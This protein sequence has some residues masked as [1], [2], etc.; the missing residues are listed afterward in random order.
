[1]SYTAGSF[2]FG[3]QPSASKWN[4]L[5]ANDASFNDGTGI[6]SGVLTYAK[7]ASAFPVQKVSANFSAV[8]TGTTVLPL[9]DTIPQNT[10]GDQ[11]MTLAI[12]PKSATNK[13]VIRATAFVSASIGTSL[14]GA[15]FQDSTANALAADV[16][17]QSQA[18][19]VAKLVIEHTMTAGTASA[20]TFKVR[21]G[22]Q[23]AGTMTFNGGSG[24]RFFGGITLSNMT[25]EEFNV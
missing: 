22:P 18:T 3:E 16:A 1:M 12:T 20:T 8:A 6:A 2:T 23:S 4:Q 17:Y 11:Y 25:I 21:C 10:E 14:C 5:W 24:G 19:G 13:L 7:M 15:L 9:D